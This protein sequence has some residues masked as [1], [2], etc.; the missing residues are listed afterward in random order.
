MLK[1]LLEL[2]FG[3]EL[4]PG[5]FDLP[6]EEVILGKGGL[7]VAIVKSA[8]GEHYLD[9]FA[10]HPDHRGNGI[11]GGLWKE[12]RDRYD[13]LIWRSRLDNPVNCWYMKNSDFRAEAGKWS[14]F[15]YGLSQERALELVPQVAAI[16]ETFLK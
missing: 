11:A 1:E 10:V 2:S 16:P 12:L 13:S 4:I 6:A 9:K 7:G 3:K 5:Y 8:F 15:A 14:V